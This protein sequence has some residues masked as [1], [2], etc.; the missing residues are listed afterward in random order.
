MSDTTGETN[1]QNSFFMDMS[2]PAGMVDGLRNL[3][4]MPPS[5][6]ALPNKPLVECVVGFR[7]KDRDL[8][9]TFA[10]GTAQVRNLSLVQFAALIEKADVPEQATVLLRNFTDP[11]GEYNIAPRG[12]LLAR[13]NLDHSCFHIVQGLSGRVVRSAADVVLHDVFY[14]SRQVL[15]AYY[16]AVRYQL[17]N[18]DKLDT[19]VEL[20][21]GW[22]EYQ[23][24]TN[25]CNSERG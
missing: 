6:I 14:I 23:I 16:V 9:L 22:V 13:L 7:R 19:L 2:D 1:P 4:A 21:D 3:R 12:Q 8:R 20:Y 17:G 18:Q 11:G 5:P 24:P 15:Q 25:I 10:G